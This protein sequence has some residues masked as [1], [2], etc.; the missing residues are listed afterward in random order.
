MP[1]ASFKLAD[2]F[3]AFGV[4]VADGAMTIA[5][6]GT[7]PKLLT[8]ATAAF[9]RSDVGKKITVEGAGAAGADLTTKIASFV[10]A[11]QVLL[12]SPALTTV[13]GSDISYVKGVY[14]LSDVLAGPDVAGN[15]YQVSYARRLQ[16]QMGELPGGN[17]YI[18]GPY[19]SPT[20][21]G[22]RLQP[23]DADQYAPGTGVLAVATSDYLCSDTADQ[24]INIYFADDFN[25]STPA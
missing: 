12:D 17:L 21:H 2:A 11:T 7:N 10:S 4:V 5:P 19:V 8:S 6:A 23:G 22:I 9:K 20:N 13:V 16:I 1:G 15:T 3:V 14:R 24:L 18:G 25:L